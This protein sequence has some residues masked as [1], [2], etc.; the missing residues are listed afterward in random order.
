MYVNDPL[1]FR[2]MRVAEIWAL[3]T[4][5]RRLSEL[6]RL[7]T[8]FHGR[9]VP[10]AG[11]KMTNVLLAPQGQGLPSYRDAQVDSP[12]SV[13]YSFSNLITVSYYFHPF[14][15]LNLNFKSSSPWTLLLGDAAYE[16][17][18]LFHTHDSDMIAHLF[19]VHMIS[20]VYNNGVKPCMAA[21]GNHTIPALSLLRD[22]KGLSWTCSG[23]RCLPVSAR[24][25]ENGWYIWCPEE[26]L[27][28]C[29]GVYT[30]PSRMRLCWRHGMAADVARYVCKYTGIY[31]TSFNLGRV[32]V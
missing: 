1:A 20:L 2:N 7:I 14:L 18:P 3:P 32:Q 28:T 12:R 4:N 19:S 11:H 25:E 10:A 29:I 16:T 23:D 9:Q 26:S 24:F 17:A 27:P 30:K 21:C 13:N 22:V 15:F 8:T 31:I 5:R 6:S